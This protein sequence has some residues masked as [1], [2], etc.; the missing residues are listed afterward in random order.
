MADGPVACAEV[1]GDA[2]Q[3]MQ[4]IGEDQQAR[5]QQKQ[6][7]GPPQP[8]LRVC[9]Q[10]IG[11]PQNGRRDDPG[12]QRQEESVGLAEHCQEGARDDAH[13][14]SAKPLA[15]VAGKVPQAS[16]GEGKQAKQAEGHRKHGL[17]LHD[18][19][20]GR[21]EQGMQ[22]PCA[23]REQRDP[24]ATFVVRRQATIQ[25]AQQREQQDAVEQ[26]Q[27]QVGAQ[28]RRRIRRP[29][30]GVDK[31]TQKRKRAPRGV[32]GARG[33]VAPESWRIVDR[34]ALAQRIEVD[35]IVEQEAAIQTRQVAQAGNQQQRRQAGQDQREFALGGRCRHRWKMKRAAWAA[36][37][38]NGLAAGADPGAW[39]SCGR[40]SAP[41]CP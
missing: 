9:T 18:I 26:M 5:Q 17:A 33:D 28:E 30:A 37:D 19:E 13:P 29:V 7:V 34:S 14:H 22:K 23:G 41:T 15:A 35:E 20:R 11:C 40:S 38:V 39:V 6:S 2:R 27:E 31:E 36:L 16:V 1:G 32:G 10:G 25:F 12:Q 3:E 8:N 24:W 4:Q 21:H